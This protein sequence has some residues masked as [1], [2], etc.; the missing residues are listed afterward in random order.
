MG[1]SETNGWNSLAYWQS[2]EWQVIKER[3]KD[4]TQYNPAR[5]DLFASL[6][7]VRPESCRVAILGQDPYPQRRHC[8]G[9]AFSVPSS[10]REVDWPP[11][12]VNLFKEYES[13][14][15]YPAPKSGDLSKWCEQGVLLWNVF[16]SCATGKPGSHHW[17][18]WT[19]LTQEIVEL[20]DKQHIVFVLLGRK[21]QEFSKF[22]SL[23]P[24][25][26]TSHPSP[27][28][29]KYG[30]FGSR[31]FTRVNGELVRLGKGHIDWRL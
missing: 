30:F 22:I 12:L 18:E 4:E 31:I 16:P 24:I 14:L 20:L 23:S 17:D 1:F 28:G 29:V 7:L 8:S 3:L 15:H 26:H 27:M 21:A 5:S 19:F 11:S 25:I 9:I 6:R 13:D 10:T 2:G